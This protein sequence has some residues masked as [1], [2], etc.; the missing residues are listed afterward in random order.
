MVVEVS[1]S[2]KECSMDGELELIVNESCG[3]P[4]GLE[5]CGEAPFSYHN[6]LPSYRLGPRRRLWAAEELLGAEGSG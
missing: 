2:K 1:E 4:S 3:K 5:H 6:S